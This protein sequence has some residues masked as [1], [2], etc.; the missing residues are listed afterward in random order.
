MCKVQ[1]SC[2]EKISFLYFDGDT[3]DVSVLKLFY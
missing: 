2:I 1:E 3:F